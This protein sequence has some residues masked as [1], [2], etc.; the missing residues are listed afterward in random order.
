MV[1]SGPESVVYYIQQEQ[2]IQNNFYLWYAK[3][4]KGGLRKTGK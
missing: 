3:G 1:V 2:K 4:K